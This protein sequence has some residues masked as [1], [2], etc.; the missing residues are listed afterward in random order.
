MQWEKLDNWLDSSGSWTNQK[1]GPSTVLT[2]PTNRM[3][4]NSKQADHL[5]QIIIS[6]KKMTVITECQR[7]VVDGND[8]PMISKFPNSQAP[9]PTCLD[10][11]HSNWTFQFH[12]FFRIKSSFLTILSLDLVNI[13]CLWQISCLYIFCFIT[14]VFSVFLYH[15]VFFLES[16]LPVDKHD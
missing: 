13:R 2:M 16:R 9:P 6:Q 11:Y 8:K 15:R 4:Q 10:T 14:E 1:M 5:I 3:S 12:S 7:W